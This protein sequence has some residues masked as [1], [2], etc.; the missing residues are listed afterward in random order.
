MS[1][2]W[3]SA[4]EVGGSDGEMKP[5]PGRILEHPKGI[6]GPGVLQA[7]LIRRIGYLEERPRST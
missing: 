6:L 4:D 2:I 1:G 7:I 3:A 5:R